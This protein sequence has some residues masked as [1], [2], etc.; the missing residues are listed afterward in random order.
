MESVSDKFRVGVDIG[1][2]FTD[3]VFLNK[4]GQVITR[5]VPSTPDNYTRGIINGLEEIFRTNGLNGSNI[6][7]VVHGCTVAT[8]AVLEHKGGP[9]GLITTKGFRDVL[10][11]RRFRMPDMYNLYWNKPTPL[12]P[13]ELAMWWGCGITPQTIA[14]ESKVPFMIT[15]CPGHMFVTDRLT[16]ELAVL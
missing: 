14:L 9:C 6:T 12:A 2:T 3:I 13:R 7:E 5:K 8:N 1:G 11:I 15:H 16:E 10:E 4:A